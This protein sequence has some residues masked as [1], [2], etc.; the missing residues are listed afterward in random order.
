MILYGNWFMSRVTR[1]T[2][3]QDVSNGE[4]DTRRSGVLCTAS[5]QE[6]CEWKSF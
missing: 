3:M 2:L 6:F 4:L 1:T 5:A